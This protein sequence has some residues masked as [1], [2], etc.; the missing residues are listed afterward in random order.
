MPTNKWVH[1]ENVLY[2]HFISYY[3]IAVKKQP[4]E[5]SLWKEA[6]SWE[7]SSEG[8]FMSSQWGAWQQ[9]SRHGPEAVAISYV[10]ER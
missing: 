5:G 7:L 1:K 8:E 4:D 10:L 9:T 2:A 6:F 3:S